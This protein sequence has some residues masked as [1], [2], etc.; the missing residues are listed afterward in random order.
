MGVLIAVEGIDGAGKTTQV[1]LL[2]EALRAAGE[3]PVLSKEPTNGRYGK[4]IR[5]SAQ[6]GRMPLEKELETFIKDRRDHDQRT[7]TPSLEAGKIVILDRYFY[8]TIAYQGARGAD[9][10]ELRRQMAE[11]P[12]PDVVFLLDADPSMTIPRITNGR[13]EE[14]NEFE[15]FDQLQ[16]VRDVFTWLATVDERICKV[17]ARQ[18][19]QAV[20]QQIA[21]V[22][23]DGVLRQYQAKSY[24]CDDCWPGTCSFGATD[25]C[26]WLK[27]RGAL[28]APSR[29]QRL[30][31]TG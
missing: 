5:Q 6:N 1:Q 19:I 25:T 30:L 18:S 17:D 31:A 26:Q 9:R 27:I 14:P 20:F 29:H 28:L 21:T 15:Q 4:K 22:L 7:I 24:G 13:Q 3:D 8:S 2:G 11:F 12:L 23:V 10:E 16:A